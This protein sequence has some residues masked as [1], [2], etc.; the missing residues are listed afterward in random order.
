MTERR[1][2][3]RKQQKG[4]TGS[5]INEPVFIAVGR[6]RRPH[7]V[8]GE[9]MME[10]LTDFPERIKVGNV[11]HVGQG[12]QPMKI[13]GLR[14]HQQ[15]FLL[16]FEGIESRDDISVYRSDYVCVTTDDLPA[17]DEGEYYFHQLIGISV[18]DEDGNELGKLAEI[19]ETGANHVYLV[20]HEDGSE[21]LL[22]AIESV[23]LDVKIDGQRMI[24]RL[25]EY[26]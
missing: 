18:Y 26:L 17:L 23:I 22:P 8:K 4:K 9:I 15:G 11:V 3:R 13:T 20:Q 7:G 10:I 16:R 5:S 14:R 24:V 12:Y 25:P 2:S 1:K 6:L 19:M 21:V